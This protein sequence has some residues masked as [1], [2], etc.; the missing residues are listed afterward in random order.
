MIG[1]WPFMS[2]TCPV[3]WIISLRNIS[4]A[5][6]TYK[7]VTTFETNINSFGCTTTSAASIDISFIGGLTY[8]I[9][10]VTF[11]TIISNRS[12]ILIIELVQ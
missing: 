7:S 3:V 4:N 9:P 10:I 6:F 5:N 8:N 11:S 2:Y 1:Q 12:R